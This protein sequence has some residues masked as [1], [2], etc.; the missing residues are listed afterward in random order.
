ML[1]H[2]LLA[3]SEGLEIKLES[4]LDQARIG[5]WRGAGDES[6]IRVIRGA[7]G[8]VRGSK[9][10]AIEQVKEF[11][12]RFNP[13]A[14]VGTKDNFFENGEIKVIYAIRTQGG[15]DTRFVAES[16]IGRSR[17]ARCVKPSVQAGRGG[18]RCF[19]AACHHVG[20]RARA[21]QRCVIG[22][23]V[24]EY[25]RKSSLKCGHAVDS[26]TV[27]QAVQGPA[28]VGKIFLALSKRKIEHIA[29]DQ[30]LRHI[31]GRQGALVAQIIV[32]LKCAYASLQPRG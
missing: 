21:K 30:T 22:L 4:K 24:A 25:Q 27:D 26:P 6:K 9:L 7:T 3:C 2:K 31:L 14:T 20:S 10:R 16:E 8:G 12:A 15:I 1:R 5:S 23:T 11:Q 13:V 32:V 29:D 18:A 19:I 17:E 28:Q